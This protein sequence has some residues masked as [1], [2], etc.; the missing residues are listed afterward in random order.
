MTIAILGAGWLGTAVAN[1]IGRD[2]IATTRDGRRPAALDPAIDVMALRL[3]D[4]SLPPAI[5]AAEAWIIAVA[6]GPAQDRHAVYVDGPRALLA[7]LPHCAVRRIVWIGSTSALPED[8]G[9]V[10]ETCAAW[11]T[12]DRGRVQREAE[13]IVERAAVDHGR[14]WMILRMGGLWGPGREL[15][16]LFGQV[17]PRDGDRRTNL[18]HRDDAVAATLAAVRSDRS[19]I[20]H[21]VSDDHCTRREMI[22]AARAARGEPPAAW[23]CEPGVPRGK[24]V[25]ATRLHAWLDVRPHHRH[26][27]PLATP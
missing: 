14:T 18:V 3:D 22:D 6:P 24:R 17:E 10:D 20:V 2:A 15:G 23:S 13:A 21:V 16:R 11:P 5:L 1:A 12:S 7:H 27:R 9:D 19:G 4:A 25:I 26:S 8:D